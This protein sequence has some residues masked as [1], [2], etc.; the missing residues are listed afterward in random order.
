M[1]FIKLHLNKKRKLCLHYRNSKNPLRML[2]KMKFLQ[3]EENF[4]KIT[5]FSKEIESLRKFSKEIENLR[6][7][8]KEIENFLQK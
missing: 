1:I 3:I 4:T 6:Y 5:K 7:F 2:Q 8:S